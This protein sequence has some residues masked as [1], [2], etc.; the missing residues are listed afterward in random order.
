MGGQRFDPSDFHLAPGES[1]PCSVHRVAGRSTALRCS[2]VRGSWDA[3]RIETAAGMSPR[4]D[5]KRDFGMV[6]RPILFPHMTARQ[7]VEFGLEMRRQTRRRAPSGRPT[8]LTL[9]V[10]RPRP[11]VMPTRCPRS[12]AAGRAARALA[13]SPQVLLLDEPFPPLDAKVWTQLQRRDPTHPASRSGRRHLR[14]P[15]PGG[16]ARRRRPGRGH[17]FGEA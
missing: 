16:G 6:S 7:N 9:S 2:L 10:C 1:S 17:A 3:G 8:C 15:R 11:T 12:A 4:A 14:H 13:I 5:E